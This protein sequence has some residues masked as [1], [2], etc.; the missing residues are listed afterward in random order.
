VTSALSGV[1]I[2][3]DYQTRRIFGLTRDG[4]RLGKVR[5]IGTAPQ[6]VVSFGLGVRGELYVVGYEGTVYRMNLADAS[7]D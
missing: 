4:T 3:A 5:Q 6:R 7:F 2:F 1:Y